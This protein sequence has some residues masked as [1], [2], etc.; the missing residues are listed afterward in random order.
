[1]TV[2]IKMGEI[3]RNRYRIANHNPTTSNGKEAHQITISGIVMLCR[4]DAT[5]HGNGANKRYNIP[6][7]SVESAPDVVE[8]STS[9]PNPDS[10]VRARSIRLRCTLS[11]L[12]YCSN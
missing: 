10:A 3:M 5:C 2:K 11:K 9:R 1:M 7:G 8:T 6:I 12:P 4:S